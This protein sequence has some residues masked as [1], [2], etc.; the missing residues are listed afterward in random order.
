MPSGSGT[1]LE[2][3]V[4]ERS[5]RQGRPDGSGGREP[6]AEQDAWLEALLTESGLESPAEDRPVMP[7]PRSMPDSGPLAT[8]V[9]PPAVADASAPV[10]PRA[11]VGRSA[12][13]PP[14]L[15]T[16]LSALPLVL[17]VASD[18]KLRTRDIT[19]SVK[20][21][22]D[23]FVLL[24][25]GVYGLA[26]LLLLTIFPAGRRFRLVSLPALLATLFFGMLMVSALY[27]PFPVMAVARA[28]ELGVWLLLALTI[29]RFADRADL[30]RFAHGFIVVVT[31]AVVLGKVYPQPPM[32]LQVGR[33]TWL[34][35]HPVVAGIYLGLAVLLLACYLY[36]HA[37]PRPGPRWRGWI[38][39]VLLLVNGAALERTGTR[40]AAIGAVLAIA[41]ALA[42]L[43]S[44]RG[45]RDLVLFATLGM[46][47]VGMFLSGKVS[48]FLARG[49]DSQKLMT[50]NSRT[51][52]WSMA[53]QQ[54]LKEPWFGHGLSSSRGL[55]LDQ[56]GLGGGHNIVVNLLVDQGFVGLAFF[57]LLCA[58][59]FIEFRRLARVSAIR[60]DVIMIHAVLIYLLVDGMTTEYLV[61]PDDVAS[62]WLIMIVAWCYVLQG[63][64]RRGP[65]GEAELL[66]AGPVAGPAV[67][68]GATVPEAS[69]SSGAA[70]VPASAP[71]P[72]PGSASAPGPA[73]AS[74]V[75]AV[76]APAR[77]PGPAA[78][79]GDGAEAGASLWPEPMPSGTPRR[80]RWG[81][82][83]GD[84]R[85]P[86]LPS[87]HATTSTAPRWVEFGGFGWRASRHQGG[88]TRGAAA[89]EPGTETGPSLF[90]RPSDLPTGLRGPEEPGRR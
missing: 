79:V 86:D 26:G 49:E 57:V 85:R 41:V 62:G 60:T 58:A 20:G 44:H 87:R 14:H 77:A 71:A 90:E 74:A 29:A 24:E 50:L 64:V 28:I 65:R 45:R 56:I 30:H 84:R 18:F 3:S 12:P 43:V 67:G 68:S 70:S 7:S 37:V 34:R 63:I 53:W 32:H 61:A 5:V 75:G 8:A 42:L 88:P 4:A 36:K 15:R 78:R 73:A 31:G 11:R 38:Y 2:G 25:L 54:V 17:M 76:A 48:D 51:D 6:E 39:L 89:A 16:L 10:E 1:S 69:A 47:F 66:L 35:V 33:F 23:P 59:L 81:R 72:A 52:L 9:R 21:G 80:S 13:L 40:G 22:A 82:R 27:S 46:G 55:F 83:G 19:S